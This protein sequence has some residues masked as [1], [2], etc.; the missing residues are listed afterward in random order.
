MTL[1]LLKVV[2]KKRF[3]E[4]K[5]IERFSLILMKDK[6]DAYS[7][8]TLTTDC[9]SQMHSKSRQILYE[10]RFPE[11]LNSLSFFFLLLEL[12]W[13]NY[14]LHLGLECRNTFLYFSCLLCNRVVPN[15][16]RNC[17]APLKVPDITESIMNFPFRRHEG[18]LLSLFQQKLFASSTPLSLCFA[19]NSV[20]IFN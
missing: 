16:L 9:Y 10:T 7:L 12:F 3:S 20:C 17:F 6:K 14:I 19:V 13:D 11:C 1:V 18:P 8:A 2:A 15:I 5:L 4:F